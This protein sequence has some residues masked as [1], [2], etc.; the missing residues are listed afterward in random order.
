MPRDTLA[1]VCYKKQSNLIFE[2]DFSISHAFAHSV[3]VNIRKL[4]LATK[5]DYDLCNLQPS[6]VPHLP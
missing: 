2:A 4:M 3:Q 6:L 5:F 1:F